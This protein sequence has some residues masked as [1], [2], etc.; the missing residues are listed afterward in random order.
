MACW[1]CIICLVCICL[2][3][4]SLLPCRVSF[5]SPSTLLQCEWLLGDRKPTPED[6]DKGIDPA[7]PLFQ[8]ILE[9]PVVQLGLTNP[10]TLLG[11]CCQG[12]CLL[13]GWGGGRTKKAQAGC[14]PS[15]LLGTLVD[16]QRELGAPHSG[17]WSKTGSWSG[18]WGSGIPR[19]ALATELPRS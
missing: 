12:C 13:G 6:L 11:E 5:P 10:K 14:C 17:V 1:D 16:L 8:A 15:A 19:G 3:T 4:P 9:N 18:V 2:N 7:S